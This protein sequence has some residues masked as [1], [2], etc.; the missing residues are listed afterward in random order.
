MSDR[1]CE[2]DYCGV[3]RVYEA[4]GSCPGCGAPLSPGERRLPVSVPDNQ[5]RNSNLNMLDQ[6]RG[7]QQ[8][9]M[10]QYAAFG[11]QQSS[12]Y[13]QMLGM[14]QSMLER[15]FESIFGFGMDPLRGR[16]MK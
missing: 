15:E 12:R 6:M 1:L 10:N 8:Q 5:E 14:Q 9:Q 2:C 13:Q 4:G 16:G 7:M 11:Q 3:L